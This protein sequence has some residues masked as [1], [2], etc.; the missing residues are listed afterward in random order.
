MSSD[1]HSAGNGRRTPIETSLGDARTALR[2]ERRRCVDEN[3]AF[4]SFCA[5]VADVQPSASAGSSAGPLAV[6]TVGRM[7]ASPPLSAV[8][9]AYERTVM[10]VPHYEEEYGDTYE[11][12][13]RAEFGDDIAAGV[14][15]AS[16]FSPELR[17]AVVAAGE[18]AA[19]ERREFLDLLDA[20]FESLDAV[21]DGI[22]RT[23]TDLSSL[24]DRPLSSRSFDELV[25]LRGDVRALRDELD[26]RARERQRTLVAHRRTLSGLVP[27]V[28]DYLYYD[29][30]CEYP[31][32]DALASARR[33]VETALSRVDRRIATTG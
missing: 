20:E 22:E 11:E 6:K 28:T 33:L 17:R 4:R 12:S 29:I 18:S 8:R 7:A 23:V 31:G 5:A 13:L 27:S 16:A 25:A 10:E 24:D 21:E 30:D 32:L 19:R 14:T 3:A 1:G 9:R 2:A 26:E 15:S